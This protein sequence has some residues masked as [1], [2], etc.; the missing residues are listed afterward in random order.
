VSRTVSRD[1]FQALAKRVREL[2]R[3]EAHVAAGRDIRG[4]VVAILPVS[5]KIPSRGLRLTAGEDDDLEVTA[6][7]EEKATVGDGVLL[8]EYDYGWIALGLLKG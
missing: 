4:E 2:C 8:R 3:E 1:P 5:I 7:V 6:H